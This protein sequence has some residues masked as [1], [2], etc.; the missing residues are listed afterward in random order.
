MLGVT[1]A[2][3][4][5]ATL[6]PTMSESSIC[7][8]LCCHSMQS[9]CRFTGHVYDII[10]FISTQVWPVSSIVLICRHL[11]APIKR[12]LRPIWSTNVDVVLLGKQKNSLRSTTVAFYDCFDIRRYHI[13]NMHRRQSWGLGVSWPPDS[14]LGG[15]VGGRW[16]GS[17]RVSWRVVK[18][19]YIILSCS[20]LLVC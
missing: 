12:P 20:L 4:V 16:G 19:H 7:Y 18:H 8:A 1:F 2:R 14:G 11:S 15:R 9:W 3:P 13:E 17:W 10:L 6:P 5:T